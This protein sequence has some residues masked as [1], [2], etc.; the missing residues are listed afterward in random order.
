[1]KGKSNYDLEDDDDVAI[2]NVDFSGFIPINVTIPQGGT[3]TWMAVN[4]YNV[5]VVEDGATPYFS[6]PDP[7]TTYSF[8]FNS[9]GV[10][11]YHNSHNISQTGTV[12]VIP[13]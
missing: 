2:V 6:S 3:V 5:Q 11:H 10:W 12:T 8:T 13:K 4:G 9:V 1:M 7:L